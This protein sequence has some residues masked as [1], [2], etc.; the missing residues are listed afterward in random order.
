MEKFEQ[1]IEKQKLNIEKREKGDI[2]I[3]S[4]LEEDQLLDLAL[5][6]CKKLDRSYPMGANEKEYLLSGEETR[7]GGCFAI[8]YDKSKNELVVDN[9]NAR[10]DEY[11]REKM[12]K[13]VDSAIKKYNNEEDDEEIFKNLLK[14][15]KINLSELDSGNMFE[16]RGSSSG[17]LINIGLSICEKLD[18]TFVVDESQKDSLL[19]GKT[20]KLSSGYAIEFNNSIYVY[21]MKGDRSKLKDSIY[22]VIRE[23]KK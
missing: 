11:I 9:R 22:S 8:R 19:S 13:G 15:L 20:I 17:D 2:L 7:P 1:K 10:G 5:I 23:Y 4:G 16:I 12:Q 6:M 14:E 3:I 21:N 18:D